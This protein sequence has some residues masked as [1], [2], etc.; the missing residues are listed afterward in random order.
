MKGYVGNDAA[1]NTVIAENSWLHSGDLGYYDEDNEFYIVD[2]IKELNKYK[3]YQVAPAELEALLIEYPQIEDVAII[4]VADELAGELPMA[5]VVKQ[6]GAN[7][8]AQ[9]IIDFISG[10][11]CSDINTNLK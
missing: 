11:W 7:V 9:E 10:N 3:G 2:R 4:A 5:F 6:N 8:S 1:T